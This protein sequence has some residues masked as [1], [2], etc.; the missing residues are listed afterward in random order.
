MIEDLKADSARW[1]SERRSQTSRNTPGGIHGSRDGPNYP[2]APSSNSPAV[3]Y[4]YSETHQSRQQYGPTDNNQYQQDSYARDGP[5]DGP[6]HPTSAAGGYSGAPGSFQQQQGYPP[7][8]AS[9][10]NAPGFPFQQT[11]QGSGQDTR[12]AAGAA[13]SGPMNPGFP[14]QE[15]PY[16]SVGANMNQRGGFPQNDN[17]GGPRVASSTASSQQPM[18][19]NPGS[20]QQGYPQPS[21][22]P[23]QYPNQGP[24]PGNN[25]HYP[26]MQPQDPF[27][28]RGQ[29]NR[30]ITPG[31][32]TRQDAY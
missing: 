1:D 21:Q 30:L 22:S 23:F 27:Y 2:A 8:G 4:R 3:Q 28:G 18:Y 9:S 19:S 25:Q 24:P 31:N 5:Y 7:P 16:I 11:P 10:N 6:R 17:F 32:T 29:S 15:A 26:A 12:F 20:G 13:Q 14:P